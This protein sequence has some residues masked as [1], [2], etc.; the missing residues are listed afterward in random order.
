MQVAPSGRRWIGTYI[1]P[2]GQRFD[3]WRC[4]YFGDVASDETLA[5]SCWSA[6]SGDSCGLQRDIVGQQSQSL[7]CE[8]HGV[9]RFPPTSKRHRAGSK[10][11]QNVYRLR[12]IVGAARRQES[13]HMGLRCYELRQPFTTS[14]CLVCQ[15]SRKISPAI[16]L[17][18]SK[19]PQTQWSWS[20]LESNPANRSKSRGTSDCHVQKNKRIATFWH[21]IW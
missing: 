5:T 13:Q 2:T 6:A 3:A 10:R 16:A 15:P 14:A 17:R 19:K 8:T 9:T 7:P 12:T 1:R 18:L 4:T 21:C 11:A 20:C